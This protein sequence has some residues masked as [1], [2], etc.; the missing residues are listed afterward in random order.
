LLGLDGLLFWNLAYFRADPWAS[1]KIPPQSGAANTNGDGFLLY[2][3]GPLGIDP[4]IPILSLRLKQYSNGLDDYDYFRLYEEA[5]GR[6]ATW[7][8]ITDNVVTGAKNNK[9][10]VFQRGSA[11]Q[12]S[13]SRP[14][15]KVRQVIGSYLSEHPVEHKF[16]EWEDAVPEYGEDKPGA[17][18]RTCSICGA[19]EMRFISSASSMNS[20]SS[21]NSTASSTSVK[22]TSSSHSTTSSASSMKST[23]SSHGTT[24][25]PSSVK[26]TG[27]SLSTSEKPVTS[28]AISGHEAV[29]CFGL[30]LLVSVVSLMS[31]IH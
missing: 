22:S 11:Y 17:Q 23:S 12:A 10:N 30:S 4:K 25:S 2:P 28:V 3:A 7:T 18:I 21:S 27:S 1:P 31:F 19:Q 15:E 13:N 8:L 20:T 26:S 24:S 14:M 29:T 6:N 16:G 9:Y 5:V